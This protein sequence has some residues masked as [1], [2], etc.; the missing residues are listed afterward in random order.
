[1]KE[2]TFDKLS[3]ILDPEICALFR[4]VAEQNGISPEDVLMDFMRDYVVS[5]GHL[6]Q[7]RG[8]HSMNR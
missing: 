8:R 7:V 3:S 5:G 4:K 1:M 6:E 2:N